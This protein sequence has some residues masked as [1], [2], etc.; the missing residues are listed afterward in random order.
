MKKI[1]NTLE[2]KNQ[3]TDSLN[4]T[5]CNSQDLD[6]LELSVSSI[7]F[8]FVNKLK[9]NTIAIIIMLH[10]LQYAPFKD[11]KKRSLAGRAKEIGLEDPAMLILSNKERVNLNKLVNK[12]V[13]GLEDTKAVALGIQ[14]V[15]A[16]VIG[17]DSANILQ[18]E[19]LQV[20]FYLSHGV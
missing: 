13:E 14:H 7:H 1:I 19:S 9:C 16:D 11:S 2:K 3:L 5:I 6:E 8:N 18:M 20:I 10:S 15:L 4:E 12:K 17:K